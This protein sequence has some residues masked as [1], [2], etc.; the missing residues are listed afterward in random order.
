MLITLQRF[1][2]YCSYRVIR[3]HS[4]RILPACQPYPMPWYPMTSWGGQGW[5]VGPMSVG[6]G[7]H[8]SWNTY[9]PTY[10]PQKRPGT[11]DPHLPKERTWDQRYP[12]LSVDRQTPVK[13]YLPTTSFAG[14]K[15]VWRVVKR[16]EIHSL[17][18]I[19]SIK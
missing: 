19:Q 11:R 1:L 7:T 14:G 9:L 5:A 15:K 17:N 16:N 2:G 3:K 13:T 10:P 4:S 8:P 18:G 12:P 6:M